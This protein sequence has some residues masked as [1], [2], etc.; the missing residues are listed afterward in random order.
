MH[1]IRPRGGSFMKFLG[2]KSPNIGS[3][4]GTLKR[5]LKESPNKV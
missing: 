3:L 5:T 2:K 1:E 4:K